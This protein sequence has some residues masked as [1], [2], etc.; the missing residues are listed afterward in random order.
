MKQLGRMKKYDNYYLDTS[1]SGSFRLG[2]LPFGIKEVGVERFLFGS[3]FPTCT[4]SMA[5]GIVATD[6]FLTE[7]QK[8]ALFYDNAKRLLKL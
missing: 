5:V 3:D 4:P 7:E 6:P 8:Q 1:G 2:A